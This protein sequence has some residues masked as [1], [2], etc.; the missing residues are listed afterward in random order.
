MHLC[1]GDLCVSVLQSCWK[2]EP[3][4]LII[5]TKLHFNIYTQTQSHT[6]T[7]VSVMAL[8]SNKSLFILLII[9]YNFFVVMQVLLSDD[10][11][12]CHACC[13]FS[14]QISGAVV[15]QLH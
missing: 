3:L 10:L 2:H 1:T 13:G 5:C 15:Q 7:L 11:L 14:G 9:K 6:E 12:C 4:I 8:L